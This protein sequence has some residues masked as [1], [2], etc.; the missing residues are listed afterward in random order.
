MFGGATAT[1]AVGGWATATGE[2]VTEKI[3]IVYSF[4]TS[5]QLHENINNVLNICETLK[6]EMTQ[7]ALTLEINGQVKFI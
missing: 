5:D 6:K 1:Q 7:E 4:C 3:T 2:I